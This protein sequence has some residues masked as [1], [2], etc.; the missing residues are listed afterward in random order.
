MSQ[1]INLGNYETRDYLVGE[2]I[3]IDTNDKREDVVKEARERCAKNVGDYYREIKEAMTKPTEEDIE[4]LSNKDMVILT[5]IGDS[6]TMDELN[7]LKEI[8]IKSDNKKVV[9]NIFNEKK[10]KLNE[11]DISN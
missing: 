11:D 7:V 5:K 8:V 2:E 1:K 3:S 10:I 4:K 9:L 6:K